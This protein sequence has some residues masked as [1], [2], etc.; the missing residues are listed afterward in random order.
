MAVAVA[1]A[2]KRIAR[3]GAIA[4]ERDAGVINAF[5]VLSTINK[6]RTFIGSGAIRGNTLIAD[7]GK[8]RV[9]SPTTQ[10][11]ITVIL[12]IASNSDALISLAFRVLV[13]T[14]FR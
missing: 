7:A 5:G 12:G 1:A 10:E 4:R 14:D 8:M 2:E 6:R 3:I 11:R 9:P 13:A